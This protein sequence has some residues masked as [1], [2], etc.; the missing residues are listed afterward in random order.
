MLAIRITITTNILFSI[1]LYGAPRDMVLWVLAYTK[2][3]YLVL[4]Q[5]SPISTI[6][7]PHGDSVLVLEH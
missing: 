6:T 1:T 5:S 7:I 4:Y 3:P 2:I